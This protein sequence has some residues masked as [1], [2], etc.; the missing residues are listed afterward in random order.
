MCYGNHYHWSEYKSKRRKHRGH[1]H[2]RHRHAWGHHH[3]WERSF[4]RPPVNIQE[5]DDSYAL[6]VYAPGLTREDFKVGVKED[7]LTIAAN[8][9]ESA[10]DESADWRRREYQPGG[11]ERSF[12]LNEKVDTDNIS[13]RYADGVLHVTLPKL[14]GWV[15]SQQDVL[16]S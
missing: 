14:P 6:L 4:G 13:A 16:V 5:L 1:G 9:K 8:R 2:G 10:M 12:I 11:F 15:D 7:V 3:G